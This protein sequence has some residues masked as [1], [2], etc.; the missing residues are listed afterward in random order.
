MNRIGILT[1]LNSN[2]VCTRVGCLNAFNHRTDFFSAYPRDTELAVLMTCNGCQENRPPEPE[3]DPGI[4]EKLERLTKEEIST[5]HVGVCRMTSEHIE[6]PRITKICSMMEE[7]GIR[8]I[9][10]THREA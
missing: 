6:C 1:C 10:G 7:Q 3:D 8:V 9:R 4:L 2:D 5:I